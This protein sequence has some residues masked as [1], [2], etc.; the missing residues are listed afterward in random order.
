MNHMMA[1]AT[2]ALLPVLVV[3]FLF[4]RLFI[5]GIVLSVSKG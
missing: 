5:Q 3:Y 2:M 1:A 4:Q